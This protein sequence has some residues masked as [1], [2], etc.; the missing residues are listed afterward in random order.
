MGEM[1]ETL[2]PKRKVASTE[3]LLDNLRKLVS[4]GASFE[5]L[6][7]FVRSRDFST[8]DLEEITPEEPSPGKY[9]RNI[10]MMD[11]IECVVLRWPPRTESAIHFHQGFYGYVISLKGTA[12]DTSYE[13]KDGVFSLVEEQVCLPYA[14]IPERDGMI[15]MISNPSFEQEAITLH[16][17]YPPLESFAGMQIFDIKNRRIGVLSEKAETASWLEPEEHFLEITD[18]AFELGEETDSHRIITVRPK[19]SPRRIRNWLVNYYDEHAKEYDALDE[20]HES[21]K[22]YVKAINQIVASDL[23]GLDPLQSMLFIAS[24]TGRRAEKICE[25]SKRE[26]A[27]TGVDMSPE[28]CEVSTERGVSAINASWLDAQLDQ[29]FDA[30][31]MLYSIGH[32]PSKADRIRSLIKLNAHLNIGA[33][34]YFDA[35]SIADKNEWGPGIVQRFEEQHLDLHGYERGDVFYKRRSGEAIAFLHYFTA[36][37]IVSELR[38]AGFEV[39]WIRHIGYWQD[40]GIEKQS[41]AEG[42]FMVKAVKVA[43]KEVS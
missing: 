21:R 2:T 36:D 35:F 6:G 3:S 19:P 33:P 24:G 29:T 12:C 4:Q 42:C 7:Q 1:F 11:P 17:Y 31:A 18:D 13:L 16:I 25:L 22:T 40:A 15:H 39:S 28:M 10:L 26:F 8:L 20:H 37:E 30:A 41:P 23:E 34:F 5:A 32:I 43:H 14:I 9:S 27:I 38:N